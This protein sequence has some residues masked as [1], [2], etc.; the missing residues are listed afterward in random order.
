MY[1][2][3][4]LLSREKVS[5]GDVR[6]LWFENSV[7]DS[8]GELWLDDRS[9]NCRFLFAELIG[10]E[11]ENVD[12]LC[13]NF[14]KLFKDK[15]WSEFSYFS[16]SISKMNL[17]FLQ[18]LIDLF[19]TINFD[20]FKCLISLNDHNEMILENKKFDEIVFDYLLKAKR[21]W[22]LKKAIQETYKI[23]KD[24]DKILKQH[25]DAMRK[26][27]DNVF[28]NPEAKKDDP[29]YKA[30]QQN[31]SS[32]EVS[33]EILQQLSDSVAIFGIISDNID[34]FFDKK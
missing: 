25:A 7:L 8:I 13:E 20:A 33:I 6:D 9:I 4:T 12:Y 16:E 27:D 26:I 29:E 14:D 34:L 17:E 31:Y 30:S 10:I 28:N 5:I 24:N 11:F 22:Y 2:L 15:V 23:N 18:Q 21:E 1:W 3:T 32:L 19:W